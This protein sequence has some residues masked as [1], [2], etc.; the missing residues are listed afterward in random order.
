[1][2]MPE[3][4]SDVCSSSYLL[5]G[6]GGKYVGVREKRA[7]WMVLSVVVHH[8]SECVCAS[9]KILWLRGVVEV[10]SDLVVNIGRR[11]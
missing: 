6:E 7:K 9:L 8:R 1:M 10:R 4:M 5:A 3:R 2:R 11:W